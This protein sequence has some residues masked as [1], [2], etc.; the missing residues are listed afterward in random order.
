MTTEEMLRAR[1]GDIDRYLEAPVWWPSTIQAADEILD[2]LNGIEVR[3]I[4]RS[5]GGRP[6]IAAS[7]GGREELET[8]STS[9]HSSLASGV[10]DPDQ[11]RMFPE[12]FYGKRRRKQV[13]VFQGDIHGTE[14]EGTVA[15]LNLLSVLVRGEDLRGKRWDKLREEAAAMRITVIPFANPDGRA[16]IPVKNICGAT[17]DFGQTVTMGLWKDGTLIRYPDHKN[18]YPM[19]LDRVSLLG[20]YFNDNGYNL[21]Y[22]FCLPHRQPETE[23]LC[24]YYLDERPDVVIVG[25]SNAGS[26]VDAP[27]PFLPVPFRHLQSRI[28]GV[29][30]ERILHEGYTATRSSWIDLPALGTPHFN[31][32]TSVY[33]CCGALP[34]LVEYPCGH[35]V[36]PVSLDQILDIGLL[37]FEELCFFGNRDGFRP[38]SIWKAQRP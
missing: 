6:I 37:V 16:R 23:A 19:P 17:D 1:F 14:I 24:R 11:T 9:L 12:S 33:H 32:A 36:N 27:D 38:L 28:G 5:A 35:P 10:G 15:A 8:T 26:L 13:M 3:E 21:Q 31:Q 25:H 18:H 29:I 22:D 7:W 4:G 20:G 30:R 34:L 2:E